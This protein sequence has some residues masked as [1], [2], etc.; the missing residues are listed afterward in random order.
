M[1]TSA[2]V[3]AKRFLINRIVDQAKRADV[4]LTEVEIAMLGFAEA[5]ASQKDLEA[6]TVFK[7]DYDDEKYESKITRLLRDV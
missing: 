7:R 3:K 2:V 6:R 5:S 1:S 4:P